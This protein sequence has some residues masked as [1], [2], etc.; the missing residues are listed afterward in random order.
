MVGG[1]DTD[2]GI[3]A[4]R[5]QQGSDGVRQGQL[6]EAALMQRDA[7]ANVRLPALHAS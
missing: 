2:H 1:I 7:I 4:G 5:W 6:I 3:A